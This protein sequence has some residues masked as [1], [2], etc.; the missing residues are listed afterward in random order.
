MFD[1]FFLWLSPPNSLSLLSLSS[2]LPTCVIYPRE[3][4]RLAPKLSFATSCRCFHGTTWDVGRGMKGPWAGDGCM[5]PEFSPPRSFLSV[6]QS[7]SRLSFVSSFP[8][9]RLGERVKGGS[10]THCTVPKLCCAFYID[11]RWLVGYGRECMACMQRPCV[12]AC[13]S[14]SDSYLHLQKELESLNS[15]LFHFHSWEIEIAPF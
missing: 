8:S 5:D 4:G 13:I 9:D 1:V 14:T 10:C 2:L 12:R 3:R 15:C 6:H 11:P 7:Y